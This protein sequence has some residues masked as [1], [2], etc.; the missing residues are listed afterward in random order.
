VVGLIAAGG[1]PETSRL[2]HG[3]IW[4]FTTDD[5]NCIATKRYKSKS[6][7]VAKRV[8]SRYSSES[9]AGRLTAVECRRRSSANEALAAVAI[10]KADY[11]TAEANN[12]TS[13]AIWCQ[14]SA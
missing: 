13:T 8:R 10:S 12:S 6:I 14:F 9:K 3:E 7:D 1:H 5:Y 2:E 11:A 4:S